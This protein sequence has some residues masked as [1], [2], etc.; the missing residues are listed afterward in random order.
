ME[1]SLRISLLVAIF[2]YFIIIFNLLRKKRLNLKYTLVWLLSALVMLIITVFPQL[3]Y[4]LA[5][6]VGVMNPVNAVFLVVSTFMLIIILSLTAIVS[7]LNA[8][9]I[10]LT[11]KVALIEK[12][13][14]D[15]E[16]M[17]TTHD[18]RL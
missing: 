13:L 5:R 10:S 17:S 18:E 3:A 11:Q 7:S 4:G 12:R 8:S 9:K 6:F 15:L 16:K 14:R 1:I 2:V